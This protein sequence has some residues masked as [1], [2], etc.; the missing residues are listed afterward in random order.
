M[1]KR[2]AISDLNHDNWDE[3]EEEEEAGVFKKASDD[4]LKKRVIKTAKRRVQTSNGSGDGPKSVFSG[5]AGFKTAP[6]TQAASPFSFLTKTTSPTNAG[7]KK[8]PPTF[9]FGTLTK[10]DS[11][12]PPSNTAFSGFGGFGK[13]GSSGSTSIATSAP[14]VTQPKSDL[15]KSSKEEPSADYGQKVKELN[16]AVT[17]WIQTHVDKNPFCKLTPIFKDYEKY[18]KEIDD[19]EDNKKTAKKEDPQPVKEQPKQTG[20]SFGAPADKSKASTGFGAESPKSGFTFGTSVTSPTAI[21][22]DKPRTGFTFGGPATTDSD[23]PKTGGLM[24][25][26]TS[27]DKVPFGSS[28][29]FTFSNVT[30][31]PATSQSEE[32]ADDDEDQPPKVE[33]TPVEEKDSLFSKRCKMFVKQDG[34]FSE[35]GLGTLH[36]KKVDGKTQL[37]VRADT[38]L[39]NILL[40]IIL[41]DSI[42][43]QRLGKN[44]VMLVCMPTPDSKPPPVPVLLRVKT[45]QEAD[46]LFKKFEEFK[47]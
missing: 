39:G 6:S 5:F 36:V 4:T 20:F 24:F 46:E 45:E 32:K 40:N 30:Q 19:E 14:S 31:T 34:A 15:E 2:G 18:L 42:P 41:N 27:A 44:N 11:E 13:L 29:P 26:S 12:K 23:K 22:A 1:A 35:R 25:G 33:F 43:T 3:E 8:D 28:T 17:K 21:G 16:L 7:D 37:I 47:K 10:D 9:S 38:S